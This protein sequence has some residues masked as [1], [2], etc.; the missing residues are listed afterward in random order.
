MEFRSTERK[1]HLEVVNKQ[2]NI[3]N[4]LFVLSSYSYKTKKFCR[5]AFVTLLAVKYM[6][7]RNKEIY[8]TKGSRKLYS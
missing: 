3:R 2:I 8:V 4:I 1:K 7:T 5:V 6:S